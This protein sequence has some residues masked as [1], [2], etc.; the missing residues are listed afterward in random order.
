MTEKNM[1][2]SAAA[3]ISVILLCAL[4]TFFFFTVTDPVA[5]DKAAAAAAAGRAEYFPDVEL[6]EYE[7]ETLLDGVDAAYGAD[8]AGYLIYT[9]ADGSGGL[10][11][12]EVCLD[13]DGRIRNVEV[14]EAAEQP[15]SLA[16][17]LKWPE[18]AA[19]YTGAKNI[20]SYSTTKGARYIE[21]VPGASYASRAVFSAVTLALQQYDVFAGKRKAAGGGEDGGEQ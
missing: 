6:I 14:L 5:Q 2:S 9:R 16:F 20:T 4:A 10:A 13:K 11:R 3:L 19:Q 7:P 21:P 8:D 18:Y 1:I 15:T 12:V 17:K